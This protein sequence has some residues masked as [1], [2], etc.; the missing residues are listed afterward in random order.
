[1]SFN[2]NINVNSAFGGTNGQFTD[3]EVYGDAKIYQDLVVGGSVTAASFSGGTITPISLSLNNGTAAAPPLRFNSSTNS[4][5]FWDT[6]GTAGQAW[7]VGGTKKLKLN[8]SVMTLGA[9]FDNTGFAAHTDTL[10]AT[11]GNFSDGVSAGTTLLR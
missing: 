4:G 7:S 9:D 5:Y 6:A 1:M 8:S 3:L 11:Q 10:D 2:T